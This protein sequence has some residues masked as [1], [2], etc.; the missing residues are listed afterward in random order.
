[1]PPIL[2]HALTLA[3]KLSAPIE[4]FTSGGAGPGSG[5]LG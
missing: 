2:N 4:G 3:R 1:M 5:Y